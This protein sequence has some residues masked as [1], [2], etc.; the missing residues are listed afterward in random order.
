[1]NLKNGIFKM[2]MEPH[3]E[4]GQRVQA[5]G[6]KRAVLKGVHSHTERW[7][8]CLAGVATQIYP[9]EF[10]PGET[11]LTTVPSSSSP[12]YCAIIKF[13]WLPSQLDEDRKQQDSCVH[14]GCQGQQAPDKHAVKKF[15]YIDVATVNTLIRPDGE[16]MAYTCPSGFLLCMLPRKLG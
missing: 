6:A 15:C 2:K 9:E 10:P 5:S 13:P 4:E 3:S 8:S 11:S 1:M 7:R 14:F 16:D 12:D